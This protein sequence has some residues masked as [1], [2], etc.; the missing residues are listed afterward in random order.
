MKARKQEKAEGKVARF[1]M[2]FVAPAATVLVAATLVALI[3]TS[4]GG[5]STVSGLNANTIKVSPTFQNSGKVIGAALAARSALSSG[6]VAAPHGS[7]PSGS[8]HTPDP[9]ANQ[10]QVTCST[11]GGSGTMMHNVWV[12]PMTTC[13]FCLGTGLYN[14]LTPDTHCPICHGSGQVPNGEPVLTPQAETCAACG[15]AGYVWVDG[16]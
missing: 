15:G 1:F 2:R 6:P 7:T 10:H 12:T 11:C 13:S 3:A 14:H 8:T 5:R 16:P 4:F 9:H